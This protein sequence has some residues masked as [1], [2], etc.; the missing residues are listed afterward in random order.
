MEVT[1]RHVQSVHVLRHSF[2]P[3]EHLAAALENYLRPGIARPRSFLY[4]THTVMIDPSRHSMIE[5][6]LD[7]DA[8]NAA[9]LKQARTKVEVG[10]FN[11][12]RDKQR[13]IGIKLGSNA[14]R[15]ALFPQNPA[16]FNEL[17]RPFDN[18][19]ND[20]PKPPS[21]TMNH[22]LYAD[23]PAGVLSDL[24][25]IGHA[26]ELLANNLGAPT[27]SPLFHAQPSGIDRQIR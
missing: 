3:S 24:K 14:L 18:L 6:N 10:G 1:E 19:P 21:P 23:I 17:L 4:A 13:V 5:A 2:R 16:A 26:T 9:F 27:S 8:A 11:N 20:S 15:V 12:P 25:G 22:F 7:I